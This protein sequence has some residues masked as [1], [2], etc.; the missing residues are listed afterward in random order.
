MYTQFVDL[1]AVVGV[2]GLVVMDILRLSVSSRRDCKADMAELKEG[3]S[4]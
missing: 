1:N 2:L 3:L 4:D